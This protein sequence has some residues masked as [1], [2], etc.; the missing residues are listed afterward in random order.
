MPLKV[1]DLC[2][3]CLAFIFFYIIGIRRRVILKNLDIAFGS[4]KTRQEK[5]HIGFSCYYHFI[6]TV[7]EF[8]HFRNGDL[9]KNTVIEGKEAIE[10]ALANGHGAY[11]IAMH[12]SNWEASASAAAQQV[13]AVNVVVKKVGSSSLDSFINE[14]RR[15]NG[16]FSIERKSRGDAIRSMRKFINKGEIVAFILDQFRPGEPYLD[17]FGKPASTNTSFAAI[18]SITKAPVF[19][20]YSVR[21]QIGYHKLYFKQL[22]MQDSGS[23]KKDVLANSQ[24]LNHMIEKCIRKCPEQYFWLHDR[25]K[26]NKGKGQPKTD[27][28]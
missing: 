23:S 28:V 6:L 13:K 5:L 20:G 16:M 12:M 1:L 9:A 15:R 19:I 11:V 4:E 3:H 27:L 21:S 7:F 18:W 22:S 25:W 8:L 10:T 17:F 14:F 2:A 26:I 24:Y